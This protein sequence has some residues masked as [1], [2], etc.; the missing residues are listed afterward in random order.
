MSQNSHQWCKKLDKIVKFI[1]SGESIFI[2]KERIM[3]ESID[4]ACENVIIKDFIR[5]IYN[6]LFRHEM[7]D[8]STLGRKIRAYLES[9]I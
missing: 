3:S 4:Y 2:D 9:D 5:T 6:S 1:C 7:L 8:A